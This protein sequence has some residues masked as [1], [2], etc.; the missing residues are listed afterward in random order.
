MEDFTQPLSLLEY[1]Y[2]I[3][4]HLTHNCYATQYPKIGVTHAKVCS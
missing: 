2:T 3:F 4:A 1:V